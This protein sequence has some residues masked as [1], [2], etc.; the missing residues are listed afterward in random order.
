MAAGKEKE[1]DTGF[2]NVSDEW[3][4]HK[5]DDLNITR[6]KHVRGFIKELNLMIREYLEWC[7]RRDIDP[8]YY[9]IIPLCTGETDGVPEVSCHSDI[10][11]LVIT[12]R[13]KEKSDKQKKT[14]P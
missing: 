2:I 4:E 10:G 7:Y 9:N 1:P 6:I 11:R 8:L 5:K 12:E 14:Q 13:M 3:T